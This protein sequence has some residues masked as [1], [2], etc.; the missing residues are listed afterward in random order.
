MTQRLPALGDLESRRAQM[1]PALSPAQIARVRAVGTERTFEDGAVVFDQ[2]DQDVPFF[3][4]IEG[5]LE[6]VSPHGGV[7][8]SVTVHHAGEF[9]GEVT[10]LT[11]GRAL[12][13]ARTKGQARLVRVESAALRK[14]VQTDPDLSDV[15]VRAFILRR[16]G[17][18]SSGYGD[19]VVIG[20]RDSAKTTHLQA[21]LER[22][23]H[24]LSLRRRADRDPDVQGM[25]DGLHVDVKVHPDPH[26]PR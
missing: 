21:F 15:L 22:N 3:V 24:P 6:I 2:G 4:V 25:L 14:L 13:R 26:L 18:L 12:V 23:A 11:S 9:T 5:E 8:S 20:S 17:L 16:M 19:A 10:L 1:F 7:E